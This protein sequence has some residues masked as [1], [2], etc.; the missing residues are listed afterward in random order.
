MP[1]LP[2]RADPVPGCVPYWKRAEGMEPFGG[3]PGYWPKA[4]GPPF[5]PPFG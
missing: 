3:V 2:G 5:C 4:G 1:P